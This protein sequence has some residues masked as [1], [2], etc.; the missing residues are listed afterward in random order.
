MPVIV[1]ERAWILD[2]S[3]VLDARNVRQRR[4]D[5]LQKHS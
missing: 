5:L 1:D 2:S 3:V 4:G